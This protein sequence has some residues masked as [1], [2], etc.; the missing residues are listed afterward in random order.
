MH[1]S[2]LVA[3]SLVSAVLAGPYKR[4][5][6]L[7]VEL[8]GPTASVSS[9][10]DLKFSAVVKN[11]GSEAV[12][13]LKYGTILDEKLPTRSFTVTKDG[14]AVPFTGIKVCYAN[15]SAYPFKISFEP[16]S[17]PFH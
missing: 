8:S 10:D 12:K 9:V 17:F 6:G 11:T 1:F 14:A 3:L 5:D 15:E 13:I 7:T 2:S 16:R 4:F